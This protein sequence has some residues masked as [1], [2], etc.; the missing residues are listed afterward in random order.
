MEIKDEKI[1]DKKEE[2]KDEKK[3]NLNDVDIMENKLKKVFKETFGSF[4]S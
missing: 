4:G 2:K 1:E 3:E